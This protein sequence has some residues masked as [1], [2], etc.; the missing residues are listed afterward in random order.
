MSKLINKILLE[1]EVVEEDFKSIPYF[2]HATSEDGFYAI[3][4]EGVKVVGGVYLADSYQN[5]AKFLLIR[6]VNPIYVIKISGKKLDKAKLSESFDHSESFFKCK[7]Y[8]YDGDV[9]PNKIL[10]GQT[11]IFQR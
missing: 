11:K 5:A 10:M 2:Y 4:R 1:S 6:G 7:A 3:M 8:V 9:T